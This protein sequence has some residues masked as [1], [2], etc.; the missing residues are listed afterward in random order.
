MREVSL[1]A[2]MQ[3]LPVFKSNGLNTLVIVAAAK[4]NNK[5]EKKNFYTFDRI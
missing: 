3:Q 4:A 2:L 1:N 5:S